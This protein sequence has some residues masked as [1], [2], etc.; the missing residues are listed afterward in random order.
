MKYLFTILIAS[1]FLTSCSDSVDRN[2][3]KDVVRYFLQS[4]VD[5][6]EAWKEVLPPE[7][8]WSRQVKFATS[9]YEK[10][11][12]V[13][14][15]VKEMKEDRRGNT[16]VNVSFK[17]KSKKGDKEN[18]GDDS[19]TLEKIEGKWTIIRLPA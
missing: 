18:G 5:D 2:D 6:T 15:A 11:D 1:L 7:E 13:E 3:P 9:F 10:Y 17:V 19:F 8:N 4:K 14:F 12:F 16:I